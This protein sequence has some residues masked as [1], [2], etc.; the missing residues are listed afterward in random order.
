MSNVTEA[1]T[2]VLLGNELE[3]TLQQRRLLYG[4]VVK[5]GKL[6]DD[7]K[8]VD[9]A[10]R[11]LD[12]IDKNALGR[13][14]VQQ[15][16]KQA[17]GIGDLSSVLTKVLTESH[18]IRR[19]GGRAVAKQDRELQVEGKVEVVPGEME[20]GVKSITYS[21]MEQMAGKVASAREQEARSRVQS[22]N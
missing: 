7:P 14:K 8:E 10:L 20:V 3:N 12:G 13:L 9:I 5:N 1:E 2:E 11:L 18:T 22:S 21:E 4:Q 17:E 19:Q 6:P 16:K 15:A